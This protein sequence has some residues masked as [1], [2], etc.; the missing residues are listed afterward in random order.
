MLTAV[1]SATVKPSRV[2]V[3]E[4]EADSG[5]SMLAQRAVERGFAVDVVTPSTGIP[6][7]A[8]GYA[9][10]L[11]MG[12]SPSVNDDHI[13]PW[14]DDELALLRDADAHMVPVLGVC[15]GAQ[16]LAFALGGSVA[17]ASEPEIGW[18]TVETVEPGLIPPG[19][20]FEW[21]VDAIT[22]PAG[23]EILAR[24]EVC[25]QAY[26]IGP[27][28]AVQFHPEV[29]E[30]EVGDWVAGDPTILKTLAIDGSGLLDQTRE[31]LP[32]ARVR[33]HKLFDDFVERAGLR[34]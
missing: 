3:V 1:T 17:R 31:L 14:F 19:P 8:D 5:A 11:P 6:R 22:P 4:H 13:Q 12:A 29:T 25:V 30:V 20:W 33:A 27:H 26:R 18:F 21:H 24:T 10:I 2:L 34:P 9:L 28:L 16:A 7:T 23:A 32:G 15:F